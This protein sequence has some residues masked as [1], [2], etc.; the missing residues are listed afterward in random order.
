[1]DRIPPGHAIN[2]IGIFIL[3]HTLPPITLG[4]NSGFISQQFSSFIVSRFRIPQ[5]FLPE[6]SVIPQSLY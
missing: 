4:E 5:F 1:M 6:M 3:L 2:N